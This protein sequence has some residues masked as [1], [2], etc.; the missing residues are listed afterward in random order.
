MKN[1]VRVFVCVQI[2]AWDLQFAAVLWECDI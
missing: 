1:S 2:T